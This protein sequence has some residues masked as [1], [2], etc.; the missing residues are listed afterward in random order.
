MR[1]LI[2]DDDEVSR[3]ELESFLT[4][5]GYEVVAV[6]DGLEAWEI[7]QGQDPP[8]LAVLDW[9]MSDMDGVDVWCANPPHLR[10]CI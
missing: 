2:A 10:M 4:R 6:S 1:V 9:F 8:R 7:L 5:A 3:L